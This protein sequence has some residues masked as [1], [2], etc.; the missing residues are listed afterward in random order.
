MESIVVLGCALTV[1][2]VAC[3]SKSGQAKSPQTTTVL[4]DAPPSRL[5]ASFGLQLDVIST[6]TGTVTKDL[7]PIASRGMQ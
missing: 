1:L 4:T 5:V 7:I 6:S 3:G 2:A